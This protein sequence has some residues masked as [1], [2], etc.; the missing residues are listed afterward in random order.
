MH[1][2]FFNSRRM[3]ALLKGL[4]VHSFSGLAFAHLH[5]YTAA[6]DSVDL[7]E[8]ADVSFFFLARPEVGGFVTFAARP[9]ARILNSV[10]RGVLPKY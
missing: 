1:I 7:V 3:W 5:A 2:E 8:Q 9:N 10:V 6:L 4:I